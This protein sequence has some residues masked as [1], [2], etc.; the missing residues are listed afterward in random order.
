MIFVILLTPAP[1]Y[2]KKNYTKYHA[3]SVVFLTQKKTQKNMVILDILTPAPHV[4]QVTITRYVLLLAWFFERTVW[5]IKRKMTHK[6][7]FHIPHLL[8][9]QTSKLYFYLLTSFFLC[10]CNELYLFNVHKIEIQVVF[11]LL[12]YSSHTNIAG[13]WRLFLVIFQMVSMWGTFVSF[14]KLGICDI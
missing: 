7:H 3:K 11:E 13:H 2:A 5:L 14:N 10:W 1:F 4:V 9:F 12:C 6:I 8:L